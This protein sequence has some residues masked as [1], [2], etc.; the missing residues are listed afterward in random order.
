M[1]FDYKEE[2]EEEKKGRADRFND[3]KRQWNLMHLPSFEPMVQVLEYGAKKYSPNQWKKG[4]PITEIYDS[5]M[6]HMIAFMNGE[7]NDP[8]SGLPHIGH[9]QCNIMFMAYVKEN[10]PKFDDRLTVI[11]FT[12]LVNINNS[13]SLNGITL[14]NVNISNGID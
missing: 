2:E 9:I 11:N 13:I 12:P 7:D 3:S 10:H 1:I 6:R 4:F 14:E 5:L 8:E